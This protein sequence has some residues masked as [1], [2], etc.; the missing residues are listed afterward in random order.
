MFN[1]SSK[2]HLSL[3]EIQGVEEEV[4]HRPR[5]TEINFV[6]NFKE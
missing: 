1:Q 5:K 3:E 4:K 6:E 2:P